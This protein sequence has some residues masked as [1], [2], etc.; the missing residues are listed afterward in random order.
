MISVVG[1]IQDSPLPVHPTV[2]PPLPQTDARSYASL[3][4]PQPG[5][6]PIPPP[7]PPDRLLLPPNRR[8]F[9][10]RQRTQLLQLGDGGIGSCG[11]GVET[12]AGG[13]NDVAVQAEPSV[14]KGGHR[15]SVARPSH[16]YKGE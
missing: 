4:P 9:A 8:L 7:Y 13:L 12:P 6:A 10:L 15:T 14:H 16:V 1:H 11:T 5:A 2:C 3:F